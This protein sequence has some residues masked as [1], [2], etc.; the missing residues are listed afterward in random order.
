MMITAMTT[1]TAMI[2]RTSI[3]EPGMFD[4]F[5]IIDW[6]A[7]SQ[8][9]TGRD[10]IWICA[11]DRDGSERLVDNPDTRHKAKNRLRTLVA[12]ATARGE[13]V[14]LGFDFPFGYPAGFAQRLGLTAIPPWRA[15]WDEISARLTD[16]ENNR[17]DRFSVAAEFNRRV[18]NGSFPFWGCPVRFTHEF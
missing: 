14:L 12:E 8:P 4:T 17:N 5:V 18:S 9:K 3:A 11:V 13:R 2:I 6:S 15:V 7:A 1:T 10:S 16:Q